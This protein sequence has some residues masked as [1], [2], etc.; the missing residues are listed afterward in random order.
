MNRRRSQK[1]PPLR[2]GGRDCDLV[3]LGQPMSHFQRFYASLPEGLRA[4]CHLLGAVSEETKTD[5]LAACLMLAL[6][7][8]TESF[9][10]VYLEAW[11]AAKPVIGARAGAVPAVI[12]EGVDGLLIPFGDA[13]ALAAAITRLLDDP[14]L[15]QRMGAAGQRK[16]R[17]RFTWERAAAQL[18]GHYRELAGGGG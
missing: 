9:G 15:A 8:R 7:S 5:A 18:E 13:P 2:Q 12:D 14:G 10:L 6:P 3:M 4:H 17:E 1:N 16:V 11:A